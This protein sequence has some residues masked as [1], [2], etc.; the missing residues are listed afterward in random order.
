MSVASSL[1]SALQDV[2][3]RLRAALDADGESTPEFDIDEWLQDWL[4]RPQP[5]LGGARPVQLLDSAEGLES[6]RRTLG[7]LL[8]GAYQ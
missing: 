5:S 3:E 8:S 1:P 7:A 4:E 2:K 6:V